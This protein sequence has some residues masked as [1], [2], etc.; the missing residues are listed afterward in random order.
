[1]GM[2]R[3]GKIIESL[4]AIADELFCSYQHHPI[5]GRSEYGGIDRQR[6]IQV[7]L[8]I[9]SILLPDYTAGHAHGR[10][11]AELLESVGSL[12]WTLA[13]LIHDS[14][15]HDC[16]TPCPDD[17]GFFCSV[18]Q[19]SSERSLAVIQ[20]LPRVRDMIAL[21]IQAAYDGD[22]AARSHAEIILA[23]PGLQAII[24]YRIAHELHSLG[25]EL[26]PRIMSEHTHGETGI[27][28]HPGAKIGERFFID[29][30]TGV[31]IGETSVIG[32]GVKL[33]QGVTLGAMAWSLKVTPERGHLPQDEHGNVL[34]QF[35]RHPTIEDHVTIYS[36]ATILGGTTVIGQGSVIGGNVWLTESVPP[37]SKVVSRP[38][39]EMRQAAR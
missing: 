20:R 35:K 38:S 27:D 25:I 30:G 2:E 14:V 7:L 19:H 12:H 26:L 33:Y 31:V 4:P 28:I 10:N 1:M 17:C 15:R 29:H 8:D 32:S 36:G 16:P 5:L 34:P 22:P 23:Y 39:V 13:R 6:V 37:G 24:T 9:K 18:F 11:R 3:I 21:D